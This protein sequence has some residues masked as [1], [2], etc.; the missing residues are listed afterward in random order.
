MEFKIVIS[1]SDVYYRTAFIWTGI[2]LEE[3]G[4]YTAVIAGICSCFGFILVTLTIGYCQRRHLKRVVRKHVW[5]SVPAPN[6]LIQ[7]SESVDK[8][9]NRYKNVY[10]EEQTYSNTAYY[11]N[12]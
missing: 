9:G 6:V 4:N 8:D 7:F 2:Y 11:D 3:K 10:D 5:P 1:K 12:K